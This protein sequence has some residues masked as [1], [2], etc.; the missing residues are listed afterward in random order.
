MG[1]FIKNP[2]TARKARE[3]A[4][5]RGQ[6]LTAAIDLALERELEAE[7]AKPAHKP[8]FEEML[9]ATRAFIKDSGGVRDDRPPPTK[10]DWDDL[11]LTGYPEIDEA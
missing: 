11:W 5:L 1:I 4:A 10:R 7:H 9:A 8:T 3:L 6:T 2:E